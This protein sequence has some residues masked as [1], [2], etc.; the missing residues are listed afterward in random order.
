MNRYLLFVLL[1]ISSTASAIVIRSDVDDAKYRIPASAFP[2]LADMPGEGHGVLIAPQWVLTA[3]HAAPMHDMEQTVSIGGVE[4]KVESVI[5]YPTYT[6]MPEALAKEALAS[7]DPA[8]IHQFLATSDDIALVK[9]AAPVRDVAPVPLYRG[10][11]EIGKTVQ[12]IGKGATGNGADGQLPHGSHRTILR[13][14]FNAITGAGA[15][16]LWYQFDPPPSGL[17]LEGVLG[18]GDSGGPVMIYNNGTKQ[19]V[20]LGSWIRSAPGN[21]LQAGLYGQVVYNV[22]VSRY[23]KWIDSVILDKASE[24]LA[25]HPGTLF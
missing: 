2:A 11:E 17:P 9:L 18:S 16:Y 8:K 24:A 14:A 6:R 7:G 5:N 22:R 12:I 25:E 15:R 1:A 23:V 10:N 19:L 21:G 13:R 4:R 3:A 20:G